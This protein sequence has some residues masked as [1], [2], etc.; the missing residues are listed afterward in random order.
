M[1]NQP[2]EITKCTHEKCSLFLY[3]FGKRAPGAKLTSLKSIR[4]KCIDCSG[5][6]YDARENCKF[7]EC[8]LYRFRMGKNPARAG[9]GNPNFRKIHRLN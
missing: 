3:R 7:K 5:H 9:M 2:G 4:E 8:S 1:N 6:E